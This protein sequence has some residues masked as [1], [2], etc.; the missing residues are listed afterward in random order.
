MEVVAAAAVDAVI[1]GVNF[2]KEI[3]CENTITSKTDADGWWFCYRNE[4]E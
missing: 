4:E 3:E 1:F 2:P